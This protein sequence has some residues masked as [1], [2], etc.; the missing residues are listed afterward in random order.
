MA[1]TLAD[2]DMARATAPVPS[3]K[4]IWYFFSPYVW[5]YATLLGLLMMSAVLEAVNVGALFPFASAI[6]DTGPSSQGGRVLAAI[7]ALVGILPIRDRVTAAAAVLGSVIVLKA[8]VT[9]LL[10]GLIAYTS[11][12]VV[13]ETKQRIF[14]QYSRAPYAFFIAHNQGDLTYRVSSA[15][16]SLGLM[17][18]LIPYS[19]TQLLTVMF[20]CV[21]LT[22]IDARLTVLIFSVGF[23]FYGI[24]RV[25]SRRVSYMT[26]KG[27]AAALA[28]EL[29]LV[30][31]F[32]TGIKEIMVHRATAFWHARYDRESRE[33]RRLYIKDITWQ[34]VPS[35]VLEMITL[36]LVGAVV[37]LYRLRVGG[38]ITA[39]LPMLAV[40]AYA[41]HRL[42][43]ALSQLSR[44]RLRTS[45]HIPDV[46]L[47][48]TTL[49][50]GVPAGPDGHQEIAAF[51]DAIVFDNV[52][53][54]YP[55]REAHAIYDVS[56][57]MPCGRVTA[58]VGASGSGK[59]TIVNLLLRLYDPTM[60]IVRVD[61]VPLQ[62]YRRES[63]LRLIGYVSQEAF[64]F[65][66]T[67]DDN[68]RFGWEGPPDDILAAAEAAH[69]HEFVTRLPQ[70]Y[71]TVVGDR[72]MALSGGQRQ[73]V[74]I[75]RALLRRPQILILDEATSA[76]DS[77]SETMIQKAIA[78]MSQSLTVVLIAHRLST[79][80]EADQIVVVDGG[81]ITEVGTHRELL[82]RGGRYTRLA[83]GEG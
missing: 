29:G 59:T 48:Y 47:L 28:A 6:L 16:Q 81:R 39:G 52:S 14:R 21:L 12:T 5:I 46:E 7:N 33:F 35:I 54:V 67:V 4:V 20:I 3:S 44:Y 15:P 30:T 72:G 74:A 40:Y 1:A 80:A 24:V 31:E 61:G 58:I 83:A 53:L 10:E 56:L 71:R 19:L 27:R 17:L 2:A 9:L 42:I 49:Q 50:S 23:V 75:A 36:G 25:I 8:V 73:R 51:R 18:L 34:A 76:I 68:I 62:D 69:A 60:G 82:R 22:T 32:F 43:A 65:N 78:Q 66:S 77:E 55:D 38:P 41:I 13:Y 79:V 64:I 63:W 57:T 26:G 37:I 45:G 11:G 70:G